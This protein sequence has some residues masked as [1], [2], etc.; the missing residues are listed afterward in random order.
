M[1]AGLNFYGEILYDRFNDGFVRTHFGSIDCA[2]VWANPGNENKLGS[3]AQLVTRVDSYE[4]IKSFF[5]RKLISEL[6][7]VRTG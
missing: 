4:S 3:F 1:I 7:V 6:I 2:N 5:V